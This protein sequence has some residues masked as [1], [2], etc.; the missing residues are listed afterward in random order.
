MVTVVA[1]V[2]LVGVVR[3]VGQVG[4]V[5]PP[6]G[7][8]RDGA[9]GSTWRKTIFGSR[10]RSRRGRARGRAGAYRLPGRPSVDPQRPDHRQQRAILIFGGSKSGCGRGAAGVKGFSHC[11]CLFVQDPG[12]Q[13]AKAPCSPLSFHCRIVHCPL[14][15]VDSPL[16]CLPAEVEMVTVVALVAVVGVVGRVSA[17]S[18]VSHDGRAH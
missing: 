5:S 6:Q 13:G 17:V 2:E 8:P 18:E 9:R 15:I 4:Q 1:L 16:P 11:H 12:E 14:T 3:G 7:S 10:F